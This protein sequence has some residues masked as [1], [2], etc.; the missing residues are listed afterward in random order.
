MTIYVDALVRHGWRLRGN[1]VQNCHLLTDGPIEEL[2]A[3]AK[4]I[5]MRREWFQEKSAPHYDLTATRRRQAVAQGAI[6]LDRRQLVE[7]LQRLRSTRIVH[8]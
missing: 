7:L 6:E 2:H 3:F 1:S 5:G 4:R 8:A